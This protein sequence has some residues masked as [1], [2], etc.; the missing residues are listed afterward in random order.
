LNGVLLN[1][2]NRLDFEPPNV[3]EPILVVKIKSGIT[4]QKPFIDYSVHYPGSLV[5]QV[6]YSI[7]KDTTRMTSW[8]GYETFHWLGNEAHTLCTADT[9][10]KILKTACTQMWIQN[11]I[12]HLARIR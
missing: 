1:S 5:Q 6:Q 4:K 10:E 7:E 3:I 12:K 11:Q 8:M 9:P 2:T